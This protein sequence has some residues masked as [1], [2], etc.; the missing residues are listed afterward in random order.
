[1]DSFAAF[2]SRIS[3][4][5]GY[6]ELGMPLEA[7]DELEQVDP[8]QRAHT[9][10]LGIRVR[11]YCALKNWYLMQTV[12]KRLTLIEPEKAEWAISWAYAT[13]RADSLNA[14]RIILVDAIDRLPDTAVLH[15][16]L[17][18]YECQL[19]NLDEAKSRLKRAFAL[20]PQYRLV[21]LD[22]EDLEAVWLSL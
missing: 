6:I 8:D 11:I 21:A 17:A 13:R 10:V 5:Q 2:K 4:A 9:E 14:A 7:N 22:D 18:C 3:A 19:G 16:N 20:E 12:A 15:Y 1:M